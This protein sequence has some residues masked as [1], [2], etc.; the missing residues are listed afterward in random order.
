MTVTVL[1]VAVKIPTGGRSPGVVP[2]KAVDRERIEPSS[3][4]PAFYREVDAAALDLVVVRRAVDAVTDRRAIVVVVMVVVIG[5]SPDRRTVEL[6]SALEQCQ[7]PV[8]DSLLVVQLEVVV[9]TAQARVRVVVRVVGS[10][11]R[12]VA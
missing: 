9:S 1:V 11:L 2:E 12:L 5:R 10:W 4:L 3:L 7:T 8:A 6:S